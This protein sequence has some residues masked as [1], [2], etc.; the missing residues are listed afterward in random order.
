MP[1]ATPRERIGWL[2]RVNRRLAP[3][4][5]WRTGKVFAAAF[6]PAGDRPLAESQI[7]RWESGATNAP[8]AAIRR[9]EELLG[10]A[11]HALTTL[12]D[13][14]DRANG[15]AAAPAGEGDP[16]RLHGLLEVATGSGPITGPEWDELTELVR[17]RPGLILHPPRLWQELSQ[18][19]L[20]ELAVAEDSAWLQ[21]QEAM[22]RLLGHPDA[23]AHAV[24]ACI[25]LA[26][27]TGNPVVV[28]PL[29]LL[30]TTA[31]PDANRHIRRTIAAAGDDRAL[32]GALLGAVRKIRARHFTR[33][34]L[35]DI[36]R[37]VAG[38]LG[39]PGLAGPLRPL[40]VQ[41]SR[42]LAGEVPRLEQRATRPEARLIA[43]R[44]C[45]QWPVD[46]PAEL[47]LGELVGEC[48]HS[49]NPDERLLSAMFVAATPLREPVAAAILD[50][51]VA[52]LRGR[53]DTG[54][55]AALRSLTTLGSAVHRPLIAQIL[56]EREFGDRARYAAAWATPHCAGAFPEPAWSRILAVQLAAWQ[57]APDG[58]G[59]EILHGVTY[60]IGTDNHRGLLHRV[61]E[62]ARMPPE[63]RTTAS[64][65]LT[66]P[67][68]I[69]AG[70]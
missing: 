19:L 58:L 69:S 47:T 4:P 32:Y 28:E 21:R 40:A 20:T 54:L 35:G 55:D 7:T 38:L 68:L 23:G 59:R 42:A 3:D 29:S 39:D 8:R 5:R 27:D 16:R 57:R 37:S 66:T 50:R 10:L 64:W 36:G 43:A 67:A 12:K 52:D 13:A 51:V 48:L 60:G 70:G 49:D 34:E 41:V 15:C 9:Y 30:D 56:T 63:A 18:R 2:L 62:D 24:D 1:A 53:R 33:D 14:L 26:Q 6:R 65:L 31:H 11:P 22:S 45:S 17:A 44:V 61:R 46:Q 25:R